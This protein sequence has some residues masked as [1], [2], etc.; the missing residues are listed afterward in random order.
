MPRRCW[1]SRSCS[2]RDGR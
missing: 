1:I 2:N